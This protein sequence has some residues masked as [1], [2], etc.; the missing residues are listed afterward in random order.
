MRLHMGRKLKKWGETNNNS[1]ETFV[2]SLLYLTGK[3]VDLSLLCLQPETPVV[4]TIVL[5]LCAIMKVQ[6][7]WSVTVFNRKEIVKA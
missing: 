1:L 5:T 4:V 3:K 6:M 2:L 7:G